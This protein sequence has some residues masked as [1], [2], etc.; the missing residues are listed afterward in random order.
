MRHGTYIC[1]SCD[2]F[3]HVT[4]RVL[5]QLLVAAEDE[6]GDIDGTEDGELVGL[7][8]QAAFPLQ[9]GTARRKS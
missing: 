5:V 1:V 4:R 2:E 3:A 7:L 6:D 8:E 9:K